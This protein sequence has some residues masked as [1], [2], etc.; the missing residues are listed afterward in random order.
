MN[1]GDD[2]CLNPF[3]VDLARATMLLLHRIAIS[4]IVI[5]ARLLMLSNSC[6]QEHLELIISPAMLAV[7]FGPIHV[8][9]EVV[10][11]SSLKL[12]MLNWNFSCWLTS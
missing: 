3:I 2:A 12:G 4:L 10:F 9:H 5:E 6:G 1:S 7:L 11:N 8:F